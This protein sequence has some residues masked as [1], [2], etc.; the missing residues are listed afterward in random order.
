MMV[1]FSGALK[2]NRDLLI[3]CGITLVFA[4]GPSILGS[5][6]NSGYWYDLRSVKIESGPEFNQLRVIVDRRIS[7]SFLGDFDVAVWPTDLSGPICHGQ[8]RSIPYTAPIDG[9]ISRTAEW[10]SG[11]QQPPECQTALTPGEKYI[12]H[13]CVNIHPLQSFLWWLPPP[14]DCLWTNIFELE[15]LTAK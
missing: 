11:E 15:E 8:G 3:I 2:R 12:A 4:S 14:T 5:I 6:F 10:L 13:I 1:L 7:K 9:V